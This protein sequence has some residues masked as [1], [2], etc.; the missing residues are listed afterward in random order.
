MSDHMM[1]SLDSKIFIL[2]CIGHLVKASTNDI[3]WFWVGEVDLS[4]Q[5]VN[6]LIKFNHSVFAKCKLHNA[7]K[8]LFQHSVSQ[9]KTHGIIFFPLFNHVLI[10]FE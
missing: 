1:Y 2:F 8:V 5:Y 6:I 4:V 3:S 10:F 9:L 7:E